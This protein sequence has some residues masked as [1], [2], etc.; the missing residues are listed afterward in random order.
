MNI[1]YRISSLLSRLLKPACTIGCLLP[2]SSAWANGVGEESPGSQFFNI[3]H[4]PSGYRIESC[5]AIIDSPV[6]VTDLSA[7]SDCAQWEMVDAKDG[8]FHLRNRAT[9]RFIRPESGDNGANVVVQPDTWRGNWSQW[10]Y[11][12]SNDDHGHLFNRGSN[13]ILFYSG[14]GNGGLLEQQ[15]S[16][17]R[18]DY[19]RWAMVPAQAADPVSIQ[20]VTLEDAEGDTKTVRV[21]FNN[22]LHDLLSEERIQLGALAAFE[23]P[24]VSSAI[25]G[26]YDPVFNPEDHPERFRL[27]Y[28]FSGIENYREGAYLLR[29]TDKLG[30]HYV[31]WRFENNELILFL[32]DRVGGIIRDT[33]VPFGSGSAGIVHIRSIEGGNGNRV[34][35]QYFD[36]RDL[37][38]GE[39]APRQAYITEMDHLFTPFYTF[40]A[41]AF[42]GLVFHM[43]TDGA[44]ITVSFPTEYSP[45]SETTGI[46][47]RVGYGFAGGETIS[48]EGI[49]PDAEYRSGRGIPGAIDGQ[50]EIQGST[51]TY[52]ID[53]SAT[54]APL[55]LYEVFTIVG[56]DSATNTLEYCYY[57]FNASTPEAVEQGKKDAQVFCSSWNL[58][59]GRHA[60]LISFDESQALEIMFDGR[61]D[62]GGTQGAAMDADG[63]GVTD[64]LDGDPLDPFETL[65]SDGDHI[66]DNGDTLPFINNFGDI[67][68][69]GVINIDDVC[70]NDSGLAANFG[71]PADLSNVA[72]TLEHTVDFNEDNIPTILDNGVDECC[73]PSIFTLAG[74]GLVANTTGAGDGFEFTVPAKA[75]GSR[76]IS[77][78][79][80]RGVTDPIEGLIDVSVN[81]Q[82][83]GQIVPVR[84]SDDWV[85]LAPDAQ[86]DFYLVMP[87]AVFAGETLRFTTAELFSNANVSSVSFYSA[88]Q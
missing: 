33:N 56:K 46:A 10:R 47:K 72:L 1:Q 67:D 13:K 59:S 27:E 14:D 55:N 83:L 69:D 4:K 58:S 66:G 34:Y 53:L 11:K 28:K 45:T 48:S 32:Y 35:V 54:G 88:A 80:L 20:R 5:Q 61:F 9:Q 77:I 26:E 76:I 44:G 24:R 15:P 75:S 16:T 22:R 19:T 23:L 81:G 50:Y 64:S 6:S 30:E 2:L 31:Q 79:A 40:D 39:S 60:G 86:G 17:W 8:F 18:G 87:R 43:F 70:L 62:E 74:T 41:D 21:E 57:R 84:N 71:C 3:Q 38:I 25:V 51:I 42:E 36:T 78:H 37:P 73:G 63:D 52:F 29:N 82:P 85:D 65:D 7:N 12:D 68:G 49:Y